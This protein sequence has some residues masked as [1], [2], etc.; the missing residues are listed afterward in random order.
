[1]DGGAREER[2]EAYVASMAKS[3]RTG[4][5][6]VDYLRNVR[7]AT[8][9][10]AY[11]TRATTSAPVS[12]PL[13]WDELTP[14]VRSDQFTIASVRARLSALRADPW[15]RYGSVRQRLPGTEGASGRAVPT[16]RY[17]G[18]RRSTA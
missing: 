7:G 1:M 6:F 13:A 16:R 15:K 17:R 12:V 18:V 3:E 14:R 5:I 4:R 11:S 2:P 8:S 10:A 9:I